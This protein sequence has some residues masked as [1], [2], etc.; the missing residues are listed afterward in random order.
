MGFA[1]CGLRVLGF[2]LKIKLFSQAEAAVPVVPLEPTPTQQKAKAKQEQEQEQRQQ[3]RRQGF[4][5]SAPSPSLSGERFNS[6]ALSPSR[7]EFSGSA[8][9][10][11]INSQVMRNFVSAEML[12]GNLAPAP[13]EQRFFNVVVTPNTHTY[14][15]NSALQIATAVSQHY[16]TLVRLVG[17]I[18]ALR[19]LATIS[20]ILNH[21]PA[22][23][24]LEQSQSGVQ[25]SC[26]SYTA[27]C[28]LI[29]VEFVGSGDDP[30]Y[31]QTIKFVRRCISKA[32]DGPSINFC[33]IQLLT[34]MGM[35]A[36]KDKDSAGLPRA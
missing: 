16:T 24:A 14:F 3:E 29:A 1:V 34:W 25:T 8:L 31:E 5:G 23:A 9:N 11:N 20:T 21:I 32:D 19:Y 18:D 17:E 10:T 13:K 27:A 6:I 30:R 36:G 15:R 35:Q 26:R 12:A 28:F 22:T 33:V 2:G 4:G 7:Q